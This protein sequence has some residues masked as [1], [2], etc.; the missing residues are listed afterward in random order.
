M[1]DHTIEL[2]RIHHC[3][4]CKSERIS[5]EFSHPL[6]R[7]DI[8]TSIFYC[9]VCQISFH[10][11]RLTQESLDTFYSTGAYAAGYK[12]NNDGETNRAVNRTELLRM[13][14]IKRPT[15]ALDIGCAQGYL[16][17]EIEK[18]FG[19]ETVG[20][21]PYVDGRAVRE[22]VTDKSEITGKFDLISCLHV[23]E[24]V[25]DP[26]ADLTWMMS[27]LEHDG[28]LFLEVPLFRQINLP[29]QIMFSQ[30]SLDYMMGEI[31]MESYT[32]MIPEDREIAVVLGVK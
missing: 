4:V 25:L 18:V 11:P 21:D 19:A 24:H 13:T 15:R 26:V 9:S 5:Y 20:Y 7:E 22:I 17:E 12:K 28:A 10:N 16:L 29:H 2:E 14:S 27:L 31:G 1:V 32:M 23:L 6:Q 3:P 30:K 8:I